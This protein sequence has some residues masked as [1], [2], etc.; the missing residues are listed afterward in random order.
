[1][2]SFLR[3]IDVL[4]LASLAPLPVKGTPSLTFSFARSLKLKLFYT[5]RLSRDIFTLKQTKQE[6]HC[7]IFSTNAL[8]TNYNRFSIKALVYISTFRLMQRCFCFLVHTPKC[9]IL[10]IL[11]L[12]TLQLLL[13]RV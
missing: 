8:P 7:W 10:S 4:P 9:A 11:A 13:D 6:C 2:I 5:P 3:G 1:M 12:Q